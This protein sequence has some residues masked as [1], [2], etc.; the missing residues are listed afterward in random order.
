MEEGLISFSAVFA[1]VGEG[2]GFLALLL[3][4]ALLLLA[5][6]LM[7]AA[8]VR[9]GQPA[10]L[11]ELLSGLLLG[12]TFLNLLSLPILRDS[13]LGDTLHQLGQIGV[14][15]LMFAAGLEVELEDLRR[16][17]RPAMFAGSIGV[18]VPLLAGVGLGLLFNLPLQQAT[19]MG[20]VLSATS[21]SISAQTL[22]E[23]GQLRT[24][25]GVTLLGAAVIDDIIVI[26][27]LSGFVVFI[28]GEGSLATLALQFGRMLIVLIGTLILAVVFL[29]RL[30][31]FSAGLRVSEGL[32]AVVLASVFLLAWAMEYVGSIA[33]ITGAFVAGLGLRRSHY[34]EEIEASL[35]RL[36]FSFFVPLFLIDIG[37]RADIRGL[38]ASEVVFALLLILAAVLSK[39]FGSGIGAWF[40]GLKSGEALRI[41]VGMVSRGEVGLIVAGVGVADALISQREFSL[42]V[43]MVLVTTFITPV[44]LR[45][46][47]E[48]R[49]EVINGT[50]HRG[51]HP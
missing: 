14:I 39:I 11:G 26:M 7:G 51:G 5:A 13:S 44:F 18:V 40:G 8:A 23:L 6:K 12:P 24:K 47:Y 17:G 33:S 4:L 9:F 10:V 30:A 37:L 25:E 28:G 41:G 38:Q 15:I 49:G 21:V 29:P 19:F 22:L 34:R 43:L 32:M 16:S 48:G 45:W 50:T 36:S 27:M 31:E 46:L 35:H 3:A 20:I 42:V 1:V 2:S